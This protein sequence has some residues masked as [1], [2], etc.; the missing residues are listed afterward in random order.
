MI[1]YLDTSSLVKLYVRE[2]GSDQVKA[3]VDRA[4][5]VATSQVAYPEAYAAFARKQRQGDF[6][7]R[8]YRSVIK[9]LQQDWGFYFALDVSWP[10]ARLAGELAERHELRGFDAIHLASALILKSKLESAVTFSS[11]D[12]RLEVAATAEK[13]EVT[14]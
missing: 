10:V 12:Q 14:L 1:L 7:G 9:N 5:A 3:L 2:E 4:E 8:Q 13:L 6:T 11:A